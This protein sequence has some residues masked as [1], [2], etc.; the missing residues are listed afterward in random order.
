MSL[1]G[2]SYDESLLRSAPAATREQL[3]EGYNADLLATPVRSKSVHKPGPIRQVPSGAAPPIPPA[4]LRSGTAS[5]IE[6]GTIPGANPTNSYTALGEKAAEGEKRPFW[7]S[8]AGII[9]V[10]IVIVVVIGAVVGGAVGGTV[11]RHSNRS[12][13]NQ[14]SI[15]QTSINQTTIT[16]ITTTASTLPPDG[17]GVTSTSSSQ[18]IFPTIPTPTHSRSGDSGFI[19][20]TPLLLDGAFQAFRNKQVADIPRP[21]GPF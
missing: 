13:T 2:G 16:A 20:V 18:P 4:P 1:H 3:Q 8:K 17:P 6:Q 7:R 21:T 11:S 14:T 9:V 10:I 19:G 5:E 12:S 15:T